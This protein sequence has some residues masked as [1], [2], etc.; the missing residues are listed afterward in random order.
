M[1]Q[2]NQRDALVSLGG[3]AAVLAGLIWLVLTPF[4]ATIWICDPVCVDWAAQPLIVRTGGRSLA[5]RGAVTVAD[6]YGVYVAYGRYFPLVYL[7]LVLGLAA[8]HRQQAQAAGGVGPAL[9]WSYRAA[10]TGLALSGLGDFASYVLGAWSQAAWSVGFGVEVFAWLVAVPG[11]LAY[12]AFTLRRGVLPRWVGWAVVAAGAGVPLGFLD[13]TLV[14]YMPNSQLLL[15]AAAFTAL[16]VFLLRVARGR[17]AACTGLDT[18][19]PRAQEHEVEA[20]PLAREGAEAGG[21]LA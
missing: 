13:L 14:R 6:A 20:H 9:R 7:G 17:P 5:D 3:A 2:P 19:E 18:F 11:L 16:G 21:R 4:M 12:G 15:A 8:L 1:S 10:L